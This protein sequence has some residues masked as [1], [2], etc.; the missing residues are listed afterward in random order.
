MLVVKLVWKKV[1][2]VEAVFRILQFQLLV[3]QFGNK[4]KGHYPHVDLLRVNFWMTCFCNLDSFRQLN[5][6]FFPR[7]ADTLLWLP[8]L[9]AYFL[10]WLLP[11]QSW[12]SIY[13]QFD[14]VRYFDI[15]WKRWNIIYRAPFAYNHA[16]SLEW[17]WTDPTDITHTILPIMCS[18][19]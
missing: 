9:Y 10:E 13:N 4:A 8:T 16:I 12:I 17:F 6:C 14:W 18:V 1:L 2:N 11:T 15:C 5:L 7:W 3:G 19:I